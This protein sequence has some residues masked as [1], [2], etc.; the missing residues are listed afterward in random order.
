MM[1][2]PTKRQAVSSEEEQEEEEED[3]GDETLFDSDEEQDVDGEEEEGTIENGL[4]REEDAFTQAK[5][6]VNELTRAMASS[7]FNP[8][9]DAEEVREIRSGYARLMDEVRRNKNELVQ[10]EST[11]LMEMIANANELLSHVHT[12][13]DATLDSRFVAM[14]ADLGAE[15]IN[16]LAAGTLDFSIADFCALLKAALSQTAGPSRLLMES[17]TND[18]ADADSINISDYHNWNVLGDL[19]MPHWKGITAPHFFGPILASEPPEKRTRTRTVRDATIVE[20]LVQP[21]IVGS[22]HAGN[23]PAGA[24]ETTQ[25]VIEVFRILSR[26]APLPFYKFIT[27]P[28]SFSRTVENLFYVSFLVND[29]RVRLELDGETDD[30]ILC[31]MEEKEDEP[32]VVVR[33]NQAIYPMTMALWRSNISKYKIKRPTISF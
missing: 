25:K 24:T 11:R 9:P 16:K 32:D 5:S 19:V 33:K 31:L 3:L 15:K 23:L 30:L 22:D 6:Q 12:T 18:M 28:G 10:P 14:T 2:Q 21:T 20:P 27:D 1:R 26:V 29:N 4:G 17:I 7:R 13:M 8:N